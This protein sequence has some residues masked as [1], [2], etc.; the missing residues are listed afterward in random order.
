M[1]F[2]RLLALLVWSFLDSSRLSLLYVLDMHTRTRGHTHPSV[3]H[4]TCHTHAQ[5]CTL[6]DFSILI[7][8]TYNVEIIIVDSSL[9]KGN[10]ICP[11]KQNNMQD[12]MF[13]SSKFWS[14]LDLPEL[15][16]EVSI[17][18]Q[19]LTFLLFTWFVE[20]WFFQFIMLR[21]FVEIFVAMWSCIP[22]DGIQWHAFHLWVTFRKEN[23]WLLG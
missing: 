13:W 2:G 11:M 18:R 20:S 9:A 14:L 22:I 17:S 21:V 7:H 23:W 8:S 15:R 10:Y 19:F 5:I 6:F 1:S 4:P 16:C 3:T 12:G